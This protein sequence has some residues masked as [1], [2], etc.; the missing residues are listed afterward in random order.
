MASKTRQPSQSAGAPDST[1]RR[2]ALRTLFA[3]AA[4]PAA[5]SLIR[6]TPA[7]AATARIEF[8]L[9][10]AGFILGFGSGSGSLYLNGQRYRLSIGGV[11][12]GAT[13]GAASAEFVG[14]VRRIH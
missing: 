7:E 14:R 3:I 4:A 1:S 12:L 10:R 2:R 13:I 9:V 8:R 6:S 5:A 11:S